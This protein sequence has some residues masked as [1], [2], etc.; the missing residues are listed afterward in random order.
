MQKTAL[1]L[2]AVTDIMR[3]GTSVFVRTITII[4]FLKLFI[5]SLYRRMNDNASE[6][7]K[8]YSNPLLPSSTGN[9]RCRTSLNQ[10]GA[11]ST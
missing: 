6:N 5:M 1:H 11:E 10:N 7:R 2:Q 9:H 8:I 4:A 3:S